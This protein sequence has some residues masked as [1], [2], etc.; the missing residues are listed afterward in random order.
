MVDKRYVQVIHELN[1]REPKG[2]AVAYAEVLVDATGNN[3]DGKALYSDY[4]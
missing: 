2:D 3:G 4:Q 1:F